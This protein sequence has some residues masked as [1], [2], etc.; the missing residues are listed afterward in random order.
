M[1]FRSSRVMITGTLNTIFNN[2]FSLL[3][4]KFYPLKEVGYYTQANKFSDLTSGTIM[5]TIQSA[6]Y[7]ILSQINN[8]EERLKRVYRKIVRVASFLSF[9][10]LFGLAAISLPLVQV[11]L[12]NKWISI[13]PYMQKLCIGGAFLPLV[14]ININLMYVKGYSDKVLRLELIRKAIITACIL[15][16]ISLGVSA[17]ITGLVVSNILGYLLSAYISGKNTNYKVF[18]Q[19]KDIGP[20]LTIASIMAI[21]MYILSAYI[22]NNLFLLLTQIVVGAVIY[23]SAVFILGSKIF[24]EML[25]LLKINRN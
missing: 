11:L 23:F 13:V 20:Y 16:S 25:E 21:S 22:E 7:P 1:L 5:S 17:L 14:A 2:I 9:P 10:I 18:D 8:D 4:G 12:T 24:Q 6:S 3:I 15:F 19:L